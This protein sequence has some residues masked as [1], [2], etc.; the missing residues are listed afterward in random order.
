MGFDFGVGVEMDV[1]RIS[2]KVLVVEKG[3]SPTW[4]LELQN[5]SEKGVD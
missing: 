4:F 5:V 3:D 1:G 2:L